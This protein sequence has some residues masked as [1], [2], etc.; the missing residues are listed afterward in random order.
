MS[1]NKP[2]KCYWCGQMHE[3]AAAAVR[4]P[5]LCPAISAIEYDERGHEGGRVRR[6][7]FVRGV[8]QP[9]AAPAFPLHILPAPVV[10]YGVPQH[11]QAPIW[12]PPAPVQPPYAAP[13]MPTVICAAGGTLPEG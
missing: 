10:P 1:E 9:Q 8:P 6:V 12:P 11:G 2:S 13:L 3:H 7:E 5:Q 4:M